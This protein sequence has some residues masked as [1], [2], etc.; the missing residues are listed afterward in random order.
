MPTNGT[1]PRCAF[2]IRLQPLRV[3]APMVI[4]KNCLNHTEAFLGRPNSPNPS[5]RIMGLRAGFM[6]ER[7]LHEAPVETDKH[8]SMRPPLRG[9]L[10]RWMV[11]PPTLSLEW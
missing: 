5:G 6:P 2:W 9:G 11:S 7:L 4:E 3:T 1:M 10:K 8:L